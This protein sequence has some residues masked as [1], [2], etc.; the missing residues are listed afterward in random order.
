MKDRSMA[1]E[2][3]RNNGI[4]IR[5][6]VFTLSISQLGIIADIARE[7]G[8]RKPK[9]ANGSTGRYFFESCKRFYLKE[10]I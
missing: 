4:D 3:I 6:N 1:I 2:E 8:Y 9:N 5:A 10:R 7:F